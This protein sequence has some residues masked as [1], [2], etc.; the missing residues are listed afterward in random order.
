MVNCG[1]AGGCFSQGCQKWAGSH[2][3]SSPFCSERCSWS[4]PHPESDRTPR[5][6]H[7]AST[8]SFT[9]TAVNYSVLPKYLHPLILTLLKTQILKW[10]TSKMNPCAATGRF[11]HGIKTVIHGGAQQRDSRV[12][13]CARWTGVAGQRRSPPP[14]PD[15]S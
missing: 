3:S 11:L 13:S 15:L 7:P 14:G 9:E 6:S 10:K 1:C 12:C 4:P 8:F 5:R 2:S